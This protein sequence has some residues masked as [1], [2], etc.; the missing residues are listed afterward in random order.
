MQFATQIFA[1]QD[2]ARVAVSCVI[3]LQII[4]AASAR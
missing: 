1:L 3:I 4:Q 2:H